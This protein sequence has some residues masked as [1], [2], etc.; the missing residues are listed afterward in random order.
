MAHAGEDEE[1][2]S[3]GVKE[4]VGGCANIPNTERCEFSAKLME[5]IQAA[6]KA[7]GLDPK[8]LL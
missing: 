7:K 3:N 1:K 4:L 6:A 5:C 8:K 2:I